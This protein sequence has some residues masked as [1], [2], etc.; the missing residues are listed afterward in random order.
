MAKLDYIEECVLENNKILKALLAKTTSKSEEEE[1]LE[2][3][4]MTPLDCVEDLE[5]FDRKLQ[6]KSFRRLTVIH[7]I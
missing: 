2:D 5:D 7:N 1:K 3:V 6:N 4:L